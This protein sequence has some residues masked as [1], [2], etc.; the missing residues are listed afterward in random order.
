MELEEKLRHGF[1]ENPCSNYVML[2]IIL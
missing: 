2:K 1:Y